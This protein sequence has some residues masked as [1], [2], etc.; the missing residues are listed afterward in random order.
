M[1]L[2][3]LMLVFVFI[4]ASSSATT[5]IGNEDRLSRAVEYFQSGKYHEALLLFRVLNREF[6]LNPRFIA[7]TGICYFYERNYKD[8][9]STLIRVMPQLDNFA[10]HER[11][12]YYYCAAESYYQLTEYTVAIDLFEK[13]TLLCY[14]NERGDALL[15]IG[16]CYNFLGNAANSEEYFLQAI[17]YYGK[18]NTKE[19]LLQ[20][21][22]RMKKLKSNNNG[23]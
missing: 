14:N 12:I 19:K 15:R 1:R 16:E 8:A 2:V 3:N 6:Q 18:F 9:A 7:Y 17:S 22:N 23:I 20:A 5:P 10:P 4:I 11:S 21:L 13:Q